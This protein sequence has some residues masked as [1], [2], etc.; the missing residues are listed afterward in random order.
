[1][2]QIAV[3]HS[4]LGVRPGVSD[5]A[6]RLRAAGHEVLVVDQFEGR[7]F[8]DYEEAGAF[9]EAIGFPE[10]MGRASTAVEALPDGFLTVG[11]SNGAGMAEYVATVRAVGGVAML[12]GA[13]PP[14]MLGAEGWPAGVP[15][16]IHYML[17]DPGRPQ[18]WIDTVANEVCAAGASIET[19]DY[20]GAGH[21]FTDASLPDEY[22]REAADLLWERVLS[23]CAEQRSSR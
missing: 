21:L 9:V 20:P 16:Q 18:D 13:L 11:F 10:L 4:A 22:D 23:F 12:S 15:A 6:D 17:D 3:F 1:M 7:T 5:A 8:D 19:F 2:A 14:A